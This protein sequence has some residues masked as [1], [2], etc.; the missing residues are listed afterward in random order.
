M[1]GDASTATPLD[2]A[3]GRQR[4][5]RF[6]GRTR[7]GRGR[8]HLRSVRRADGRCLPDREGP[9]AAGRAD[10]P[11][12]PPDRDRLQVFTGNSGVI[13]FGA[14]RVDGDRRL[15]GHADEPERVV[16][17]ESD[18]KRSW[19]HQECALRVPARDP[20]RDRGD[21]SDRAPVRVRLRP[22]VGHRRGDRDTGL[23]RDRDHRD[24]EL[25]S[26]SRTER[27][28][29]TVSRPIRTTRSSGG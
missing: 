22:P 10:L 7:A 14:C 9:D 24:R 26:R 29:S 6:L 28:R 4:L 23:L 18:R 5:T 25:E 20:D 2:G 27:S 21:V 8:R 19:L 11:R 13:S 12:L 3:G 17:S 1:S 16:E 15:H